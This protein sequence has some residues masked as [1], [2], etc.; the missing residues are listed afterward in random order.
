[1]KYRAVVLKRLFDPNDWIVSG[2]IEI[3][4][5][6]LQKMENYSTY[7]GT[8]WFLHKKCRL[9]NEICTRAFCIYK[10][11]VWK[12]STSN[13]KIIHVYF[14][15]LEWALKMLNILKTLSQTFIN[16]WYLVSLWMIILWNIT[17][18]V[19]CILSVFLEKKIFSFCEQVVD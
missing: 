3:Y 6:K 9:M 7:L 17:K 11:K 13:L 1:M 18:R 16:L 5:K 12:K 8:L 2:T 10:N 4:K 15:I 14:F 19:H